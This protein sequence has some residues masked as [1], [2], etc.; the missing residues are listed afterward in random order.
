[1]LECPVSAL[2]I[3]FISKQTQHY[4]TRLPRK[5]LSSLFQLWMLLHYIWWIYYSPEF[6]SDDQVQ[7][8]NKWTFEGDAG[9]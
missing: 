5:D 9:M 6:T 2:T 3:Y 1:M 4:N 7:K 8:H